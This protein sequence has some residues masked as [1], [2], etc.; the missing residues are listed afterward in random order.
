MVSCI[1]KG[2]IIKYSILLVTKKYCRSKT[3]DCKGISYVNKVNLNIKTPDDMDILD[4]IKIK[5]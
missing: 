2:W 5:Y 3:A 1:Y 4:L